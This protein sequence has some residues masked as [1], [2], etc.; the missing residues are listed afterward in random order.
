MI[1]FYCMSLD[2]F[3]QT[4]VQTIDHYQ[5]N[6]SISGTAVDVDTADWRVVVMFVNKRQSCSDAIQKAAQELGESK[7][8]GM[9]CIPSLP[10][11]IPF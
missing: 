7:T 8:G 3:L 11:E 4:A 5:I 2:E 6:P 10:D 1:E 9:A